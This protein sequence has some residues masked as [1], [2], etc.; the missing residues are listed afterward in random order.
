MARGPNSE[1]SGSKTRE[2]GKDATG[3]VRTA[4]PS[5]P[6]D[7]HFRTLSE[8]A[9]EAIVIHRDGVLLEANEQFY[10]MFGYEAR[11]LLGRQIVPLIIAP[12][13]IESVR[14]Q[15]RSGATVSYEATGLKRDGT[16]LPLE[17][18]A[19]PVEYNGEMV[20]VG[21]IRDISERKRTEEALRIALTDSQ[22]RQAEVSALLKSSRSVL[23]YTS[24]DA[25]ARSIF[26][27][28]KDSIGATAGYVALL[29]GDG[30]E[31]ELLF[32]ESG[33]LPCTVDPSLPMPIRGLRNEAY[34][35]GRTVYHNDFSHSEWVRFMPEGHVQM[36]NVLFAP[37]VIEGRTSGLLGLANKPGGFNEND[38]RMATAFGELA[39]VALYNSRTLESLEEGEARIRSIVETACDAIISVDSRGVITY[40]NR[41]AEMMF[42]YSVDEI[43][44]KPLTRIMPQ[45]FREVH[46]SELNRFVS[47]RE[48]A[49]PQNRTEL[50]GLRKDGSQFPVELSLAD[51]QTKEG[52][53]FTGI[54]RDISDRKQ[55]EEAL[56]KAHEDLER[57]VENRTAQLRRLSSKLLDAHE[58]ER[59]RIG[60]ELHDGI[61]QTLSAIKI[62]V[63]A[64]HVQMRQEN[65]VEVAKSL[66]A[67]A[68]LAQGAVEEVRRISR[69][70]R[71]PILDDLGILAT[72][73]SCCQEFGT[74]YPG[75]RI[76][77]EIGIEENAVPESL[78]IVIFRIMQEALN[79]IA[80]HSQADLVRL[81]LEKAGNGLQLTIRDN[82]VGF[83]VERVLSGTQFRR[84]LGLAGMKERAELS[85]GRFS[86]ESRK[87]E[88]ATLRAY[89]K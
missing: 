86:I 66:G 77:Q 4:K 5:T 54:V 63:E 47:R 19:K 89:W 53:F 60:Q 81:S 26:D 51:W 56:R 74:L 17:I 16:T 80:K 43:V 71:P 8:A 29:S 1:E 70:L 2:S 61:A 30:E 13:S 11:Q 14:K 45:Q 49:M 67:V 6:T 58:E 57:R 68:P 21:A 9:F 64:A 44:G 34:R 50:S 18:R 73:S 3:R 28:C 46:Q 12:E 48:A 39:A 31:N 36:D 75:I 37:L 32:L 88:Y 38:S 65:H 52:M 82:G 41:G 22:R 59:K 84:G 27:A 25:A 20:R 79:N 83:D 42:G 87:G 7:V 33:G 62:W 24:F 85:G 23:K 78:K 55:A 15:I 72:I 35:T 40:W 69:N 10:E 76:E